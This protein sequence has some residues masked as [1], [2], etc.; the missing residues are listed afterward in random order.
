MASDSSRKILC[1]K[2]RLEDFKGTDSFSIYGIE[3]QSILSSFFLPKLKAPTN[4]EP[5]PIRSFYLAIGI[6]SWSKDSPNSNINL[7]G[8][9]WES[10]KKWC[11][12]SLQITSTI[13]NYQQ[14]SE[15]LSTMHIELHQ[16]T[17]PFVI[18]KMNAKD[19]AMSAN[20]NDANESDIVDVFELLK[21]E[22][23][24]N[25]SPELEQQGYQEAMYNQDKQ[26][27]EIKTNYFMVQ[28]EPEIIPM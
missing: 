17:T 3:S 7:T 23:L 9:T 21:G 26:C 6:S 18:E 8:F 10:L 11:R 14:L 15:A 13:D 4:G 16:A 25:D 28:T 22:I 27:I 5:I 24:N 19:I 20:A 1:T 12:E 2:Y